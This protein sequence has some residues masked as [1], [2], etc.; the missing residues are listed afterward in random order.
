VLTL[1]QTVSG[2]IANGQDFYYRVDV[3]A[4]QDVRITANFVASPE[5]E[6]FVRRGTTPDRSNFDQS[7]NLLNTRQQLLLSGMQAGPYYILIHGR[8]AAAGGKAFDLTAQPSTVEL[9]DVSPRR[10]SN[11]GRVTLTLHGSGFSADAVVSLI[12][13]DGTR[14]PATN[15]QFQDSGTLFATFDLTGLSPGDYVVRIDES[16]RSATGSGAF[17][18]TATQPVGNLFLRLSSLRFIRPG[19]QGYVTVEYL[20]TSETDVPAPILTVT[21][22]NADFRMPDQDTFIGKSVQ[23]LAINHDGPAG[24][25]PPGAGGTFTL[26]FLP[27]Q[28]GADI[29]SNFRV[30]SKK[31]GRN[32]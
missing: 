24:V 13:G 23:L 17:T 30:Y 15:V 32:Q 22:D 5:A 7:S 28:V 6:I 31:T 27:E 18:V 26:F 11:Q 10:G 29:E 14:R 3:P 16:G 20:N 21:S 9:N 2:T 8:E 25:L 1:D 12:G 19:Q 4:G